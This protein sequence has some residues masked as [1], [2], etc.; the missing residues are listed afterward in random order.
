MKKPA[1]KKA[2]RMRPYGAWNVVVDDLCASGLFMSKTLCEEFALRFD[3]DLD[4]RVARVIV[5]ELPR[6]D[7]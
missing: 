7:D 5:R 3:R 6:A 4:V 2:A 1:K